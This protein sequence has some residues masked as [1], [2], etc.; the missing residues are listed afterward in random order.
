MAFP[1][2]GGYVFAL[3]Y[4]RDVD[5]VKNLF[6]G[7]GSVVYDGVEDSLV[8]ISLIACEEAKNVISR[9]VRAFLRLLSVEDCVQAGIQTLELEG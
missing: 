6:A 2:D 7:G 3:T 4:G 8:S 9:W 5:W 1:T